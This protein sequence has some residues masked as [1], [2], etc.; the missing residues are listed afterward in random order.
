MLGDFSPGAT[1]Q[2][3]LFDDRPPRPAS[4]QLMTVLDKVNNSRLGKLWFAGQ[5]IEPEWKMKREM[6]SPAYTT[7]WED[8]PNAKL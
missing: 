8:V 6:L 7:R 5:G 3:S 1:A 4:A 2:L